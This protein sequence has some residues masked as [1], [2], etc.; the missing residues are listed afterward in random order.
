MGVIKISP[1]KIKG[2]WADGFALD[3]HT[4]SS[5]YIGDDEYGHPQYDTKRTELGELLY[6]L[7][8]NRDQSVAEMIVTTTVDFVTSKAWPIDLVI[9]VPPSRKRKFQPVI[10]LAEQVAGRLHKPFSNSAVT[11]IKDNPELKN[12]YDF[13]D[14][15]EISVGAFQASPEVKG[16]NVLLFDDLYRSGATMNAVCAQLI[17]SGSVNVYSLA[18]TM[19]RRRR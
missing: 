18:L 17:T 11:K 7:K 8:Y 9:P 1:K 4:V 16:K 19:T 2:K 15:M 13:N 5:E 12:I 10:A 14:R 6:R 3:Y